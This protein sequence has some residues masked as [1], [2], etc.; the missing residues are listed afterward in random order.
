LKGDG[1]KGGL[2]ETEADGA[3]RERS[4]LVDVDVVVAGVVVVVLMVV[5]AAAVLV[6]VE[7]VMVV[8]EASAAAAAVVVVVMGVAVSAMVLRAVVEWMYWCEPR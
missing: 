2:S 8:L 1:Q 4:R 5:V 3:G 6:V 7:V